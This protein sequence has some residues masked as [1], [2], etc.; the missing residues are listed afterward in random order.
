MLVLEDE[1][2]KEKKVDF[3]LYTNQW[4][5]LP[6]VPFLGI[7]IIIIIIYLLQEQQVLWNNTWRQNG[8]MKNAGDQNECLADFLGYQPNLRVKL[9]YFGW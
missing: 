5:C 1:T 4:D 2:E 7:I 9:M 3:N 8:R 6:N